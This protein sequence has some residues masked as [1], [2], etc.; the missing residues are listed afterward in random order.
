MYFKR[1]GFGYWSSNNNRYLGRLSV[2]IVGTLMATTIHF[3][4]PTEDARGLSAPETH[5]IEIRSPQ[6]FSPLHRRVEDRYMLV[7]E[8]KA[9]ISGSIKELPITLYDIVGYRGEKQILMLD[10]LDVIWEIS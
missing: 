3:Y 1:N 7:M 9:L 6:D 10:P 2:E 5:R 4:E 8:P